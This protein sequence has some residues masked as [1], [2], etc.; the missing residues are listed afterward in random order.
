MYLQVNSQVDVIR[1]SSSFTAVKINLEFSSRNFNK[2]ALL[3]NLFINFFND[4]LRN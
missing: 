1:N 3:A 4:P 2:L